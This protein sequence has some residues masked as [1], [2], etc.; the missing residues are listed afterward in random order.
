MS[1]HLLLA[2]ALKFM[3]SQ[4]LV[5][6]GGTLPLQAFQAHEQNIDVRLSHL[7]PLHSLALPEVI[8]Q[9]NPP[10]PDSV[11]IEGAP[12][13]PAMVKGLTRARGESVVGR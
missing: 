7:F 12:A 10:L 3:Q 2:H 6:K 13:M 1:L 4:D 9:K 5:D 11:A 8:G